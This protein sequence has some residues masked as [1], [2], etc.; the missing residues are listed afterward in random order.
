LRYDTL[1]NWLSRNPIL[2]VG[3]MAVAKVTY[4]TTIASSD[5]VPLNTPPA[6]GLK[7]GDGRSRF[8]E[9]PWV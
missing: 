3:E 5:S 8:D 2:M 7:V 4:G 6:I 9:L 1:E